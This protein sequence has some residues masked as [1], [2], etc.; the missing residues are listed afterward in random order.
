MQCDVC[1]EN[2]ATVFFTQMMKGEQQQVSLCEKCSKEKGV[3]DPTGFSLAE[4]LLGVGV[5]EST[6][7]AREKSCPKCGLPQSTFRKSG[8]LGCCFC[9]T[10]FAENINHLLKA[11]HKG[12]QHIGKTPDGWLDESIAPLPPAADR[13]DTLNAALAKAVEGEQYEEAARIRDEI[14]RAEIDSGKTTDSH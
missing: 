5:K 8:R 2:Q 10:V 3:T 12:V 9:Y 14:N 4:M 7:P 13:L 11:M 6:A 1:K